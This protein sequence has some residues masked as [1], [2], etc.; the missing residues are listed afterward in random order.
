[1]SANRVFPKAIADELVADGTV[2]GFISGRVYTRLAPAGVAYPYVVIG[3]S[4]G[5]SPRLAP[6]EGKDYRYFVKC[7]SSSQTVAA[8]VASAVYDAL[9][10]ADLD[11]DSPWLLLQIDHISDFEF[12]ENVEREKLYHLGG[13]YR[14]R[15]NK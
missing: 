14:I 13:V 3:L 5:V 4:A 2:N 1:M 6:G 8:Q 11:L 9:D 12:V 15:A 7:I 10:N